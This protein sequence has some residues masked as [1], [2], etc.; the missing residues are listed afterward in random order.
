MNAYSSIRLTPQQ[1]QHICMTFV[2]LWT[3]VEDVGPAL[4]NVIQ[5]FCV[6]WV[7]NQNFIS[8]DIFRC[9]VTDIAENLRSLHS[10]IF[11]FQS[12]GVHLILIMIHD[13]AVKRK[14]LLKYF[15][16]VVVY[17]YEQRLL[18]KNDYASCIYS[19]T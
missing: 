10:N 6:C 12:I 4:T 11:Q 2:Q 18:C 15:F 19:A 14:I 7:A 8:M 5:M 17:M 3:N 16:Y 9:H 13:D 1:T